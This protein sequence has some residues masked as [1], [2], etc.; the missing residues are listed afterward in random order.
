MAG[1]PVRTNAAL[2]APGLSQMQQ[3]AAAKYA[4]GWTGPKLAVRLAAGNRNKAKY[5]RSQ[6]R[7][8][9]YDPIFQAEVMR[10]A[11]AKG[12]SHIG[13]S[14]EGMAQRAARRP[15]AAKLFWAMM[16]FHNDKV[17]HEHSGDIQIHVNIPRP[18]TTVDQI[19]PGKEP[20][21]FV[22]ADVVEDE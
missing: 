6:F 21:S 5:L 13:P 16:G 18:P 10:L 4:Q 14:V 11:R 12:L 2:P 1:S 20:E 15:D 3:L 19:G 22:D 8:W 7:K 17:S 9:E